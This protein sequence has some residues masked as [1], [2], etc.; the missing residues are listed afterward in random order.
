M[1]TS[2]YLTQW[3]REALEHPLNLHNYPLIQPNPTP[4]KL[5]LPEMCFI[6]PSIGAISL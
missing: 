5:L 2:T 1:K 3:S 6:F 4:K